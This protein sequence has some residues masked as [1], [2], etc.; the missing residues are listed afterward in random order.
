MSGKIFILA[1]FIFLII[2]LAAGVPN[3]LFVSKTI[4][5]EARIKSIDKGHRW[6]TPTYEYTVKNKNYE[7]EGSSSTY[8]TYSI[9]DKQMIYYDPENP[10]NNKIDSFMNLWFVPVFCGGFFI[11]LFFVGILTVFTKKSSVKI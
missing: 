9:G 7:F 1:S 8:G 6:I 11:V 4:K 10:E 3:Y 2:S 5:T